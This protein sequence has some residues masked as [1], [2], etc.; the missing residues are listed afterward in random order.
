MSQLGELVELSNGLGLRVITVQIMRPGTFTD[1]SGKVVSITPQDLDLYAA[2]FAAGLA[3]QELPVFFGHPLPGVRAAEPAAAWFRSMFVQAVNGEK[4]L[5]AEIELSDLGQAALEGGRYRYFSPTIDL[6]AKV[7]KGGGF[8]NLPAIKGL[9]AIELAGFLQEVGPMDDFTSRV[10]GALRRIL[11]LGTPGDEL[12]GDPGPGCHQIAEGGEDMNEEELRA[13]IRQ[14][15]E[16]EFAEKVKA[17]HDLAERIRLEEREKVIAELTQKAAVEEECAEFAAAVTGGEAGL[18]TPAEEVK[19]FLISLSLEQREAAK[20]L[21]QQKVVD[22]GEHG[23]TGGGQKKLAL[24]PLMAD[25]LKTWLK[26]RPA[27]KV[28]SSVELFCEANSI[29]LAEYDLAEFL[30]Q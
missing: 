13:Q 12:A 30:P 11:G 3:G 27:D 28:R 23:H 6:E 20:K 5:V 16:A 1:M 8:V 29:S 15:L 10:L 4:R 25:T 24:P 7:I 18:S 14:Q 9:P 21:L 22:F 26:G 17:E 2:N 19:A